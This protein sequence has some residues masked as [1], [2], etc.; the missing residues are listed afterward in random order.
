MLPTPHFEAGLAAAL[1]DTDPAGVAEHLQP[2]AAASLI[3][4]TTPGSYELSDLTYRFAAAQLDADETTQ[5]RSAAFDRAI[6]WMSVR[7]AF[8]PEMPITRDYW[9]ADDTLGYSPYAD[10]IAAFV[11]HRGTR[12]PLTIGVTA[13][14]GA[15]KTSLMRMVQERLDPRADRERWT[16]AQLRLTAEARK[17]LRAR[18]DRLTNSELLHRTAE[19]PIEADARDLDVEPPQTADSWRP[20]VWFNPWMYQNGEQIWAGLA[21][22]IITQVTGRLTT[23]DRERFWLALNLRRIDRQVLR[24]RIY[25]QLVDRFLPW[26]L[27]LALAVVLATAGLFLAVVLPTIAGYLRI[28]AAGLMSLAGVTFSI[29]AL[30]ATL[31]FLGAKAA[32]SFGPLLRVPDPVKTAVDQ[33][34]TELKGAYTDLFPDPAYDRRLGF[35]HLVQTDMRRVLDLI[36]TQ[37][38][39][40]VVF[41]DDLDRCSPGAVVQVIEA[42]NLFLAGEFPNCVFV[43]AMEPAVVAA[44]VESVYKDLAKH[45][46]VS[47]STAEG[48]TLGWR[49]LE[50]IVQLP[51][52]LPPPDPAR[53]TRGYLDSLL[54]RPTSAVTTPADPAPPSA[55]TTTAPAP[56]AT[57]DPAVTRTAAATPAPVTA[58]ATP[59]R[60]A[61]VRTLEAAIR[62]RNPTTGSLAEVAL[63]A[64]REVLPGSPETVLPET[65]E[66]AN[67]VLVELYSDSEARTAILAGVPGLASDNPRE[68]K[69][70]VNLFRFY[71]FIA[72]QHRLQGLS[73]AGGAEI[74]KLCVLAIRWPNLLALFG[75]PGD[76]AEP[77][78]L[79][80]L[81]SSVRDGDANAWRNGLRRVGLLVQDQQVQTNPAWA[82]ELRR[83]LSTEP[84]IADLADRML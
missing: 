80:H 64:Q 38:R 73:P 47:R 16:P 63:Q 56:A 67:R 3:D 51:L 28:G 25:R 37:E 55:T 82:E 34:G 48:A 62:R 72:Q 58:P 44:H 75:R 61:L 19:P 17:L 40:L 83:F 54:E 20:T 11:R 69:R 49:F 78:N 13:P 50:K 7:T 42:I 43:V 52:N 65:S 1:L 5:D 53:Q 46:E 74:A 4:T 36:A 79:G 8:S 29:G 6:R 2:L 31:K 68:I 60:A 70:F 9:T 84:R 76:H 21:Y 39:P 41:V 66:A 71:S 10:A 15:G 27:W 45:P 59:D 57:S 77:T 18:T 24:R 35:L 26:L 14:W 32:G 81:E 33:S 23:A 12:P 22:E 30:V